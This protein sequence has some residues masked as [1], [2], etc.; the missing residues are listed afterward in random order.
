MI[1]HIQAEREEVLARAEARGKETGR[2]VPRELLESSMDAVPKSVQVLAPY[3][4]V[5][6]RVLNLSN[7]EPRMEREPAAIHPPLDVR[8]NHA[9]LSKLWLPIDTDG[10][11]ELSKAEVA[12]ALATGILTQQVLDSVDVNHDG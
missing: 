8:I 3:V 2:M 12:A 6:I 9:Y 7:Q 1:L 10:D 4:D 11:G 5:A